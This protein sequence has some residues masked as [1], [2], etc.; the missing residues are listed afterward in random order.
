MIKRENFWNLIGCVLGVIIL[1][2]GVVFCV[3]PP[4]SYY[5]TSTDYAT[6][7]AD[8]YTYQYDATRAVASNA[9]VTANNLREI[10][11]AQARYIGVLLMVI[12]ALTVVSYG[13]KYFTYVPDEVQP[14]TKERSDD[15]FVTASEGQSEV[16]N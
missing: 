14:K 10:G 7:G 3:T 6:F 1:L 16:L 8:Y 12:G 5:T 15:E 9:A 4:D 2:V 11:H 13:K